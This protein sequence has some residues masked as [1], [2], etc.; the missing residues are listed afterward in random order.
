MKIYLVIAEWYYEPS[1]V[2][3]VFDSRQ[4]AEKYI[5]DFNYTDE[6]APDEFYIIE[7]N[8]R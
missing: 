6:F 3:E 1:H 2:Q 5:R 4:K 8:V 7:K